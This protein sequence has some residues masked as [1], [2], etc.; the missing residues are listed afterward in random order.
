MLLFIPIWMFFLFLCA[1]DLGHPTYW[2][3]ASVPRNLPGATNE[4][5]SIARTV[6]AMSRVNPSS[7]QG[8][9]FWHYFYLLY[10]LGR[11]NERE[12]DRIMRM[13][14]IAFPPAFSS[15]LSRGRS[16]AI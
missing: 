9:F 16:F 12:V 1:A 15:P 6:V 4:A 14:S 2:E 5:I 3:H 11:Q 8:L 13:P 7:T 10:K